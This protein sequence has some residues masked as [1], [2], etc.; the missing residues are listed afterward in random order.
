[1]VRAASPAA[2]LAEV[3]ASGADAIV[4][5]AADGME[6]RAGALRA[7]AREMTAAAVG[8]A[9]GRV[10]GRDG[11]ASRLTTQL[12]TARFLPTVPGAIMA[13]R[14]ALSRA[15]AAMADRAPDPFWASDLAC[16]LSA[17]GPVLS[18]DRILARSPTPVPSAAERLPFARAGGVRGDRPL[19]L[20]YG[21]I[22]AS[23]S[24]HFDGLPADLAARLRFLQPG[25]LFSDIG[26]LAAAGLVIVVREFAHM[27]RSG[28]CDLLAEIGV[29]FVWFTD[30]DLVALAAEE[31]AFRDYGRDAVASF[32]DRAAGILTTSAPLAR[33]L[34][35]LHPNVIVWPCVYDARLAPHGAPPAGPLAVGVFGGAFRRRS[36]AEHVAPALADLAREAPVRCYAAAGIAVPLAE[37]H[38]ETLPFQP[39]YRSFVFAWQRLGLRAVAHPYGVSGNMPN[40]GPASVLT[41]AYLGAVPIVGAE[42]AH[43]GLSEENGVLVAAP[44]PA[45]WKRALSRL[46]DPTEAAR[47]F[48]RLDAWCRTALDPEAARAP[49]AALDRL[50]AAGGPDAEALRW[51]HA[52]RSVALRRA[53]A[54]PVPLPPT[55]RS[56]V[57]RAV[58]SRV[59]RLRAVMR[60]P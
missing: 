26:W 29:P 17:G 40:K 48:A 5:L 6:A 43:A 47:L 28:A 20:V 45:S 50:A 7:T 19:I 42:A 11:K 37:A 59:R 38:L 30:D 31:A 3:A 18:T 39:G 14:A 21:K 41:A 52:C 24:I 56:R 8:A 34:S 36:F 33:T 2:L 4:H 58:R 12:E 23:V 13:T 46:A 55:L 1:M 35:A 22:E 49:F 15:A 27:L 16:A 9:I 25:D 53:A 10:E 60:A 57:G 44:D 32:L 51:Q 54:A